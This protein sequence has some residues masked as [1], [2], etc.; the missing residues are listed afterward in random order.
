MPGLMLWGRSVSPRNPPS[1]AGFANHA[2]ATCE[3]LGERRLFSYSYS[4]VMDDYA[5]MLPS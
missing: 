2:P 4:V 1:P 5:G 3:R